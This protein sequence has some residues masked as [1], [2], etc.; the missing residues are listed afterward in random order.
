M[1]FVLLNGYSISSKRFL[2]TV[3]YIMF[4]WIKFTHSRPFYFTDSKKVTVHSCYLLFGHFQFT[5]IHGLTFQVPMQYCSLL[6]PLVTSKTGHC[7]CFSSISSFFVELFLQSSPVVYIAFIHLGG[8]S[9]SVL[10]AFSYCSW[11]PQGKNT[12]VFCHFLLPQPHPK[13][14]NFIRK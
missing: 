5:L 11:G 7:F 6:L 12:E 9:F 2:P 1:R 10:F 3:V 13:L 14:K 4:I 8:S